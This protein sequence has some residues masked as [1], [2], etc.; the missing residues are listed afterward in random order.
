MT[1]THT[2]STKDTTMSATHAHVVTALTCA[3]TA[4]AITAP[5]RPVTMRFANAHTAMILAPTAH[6]MTAHAPHAST[7]HKQFLDYK[8]ARRTL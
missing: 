5:A 4:P 3:S 2:A 8:P 1:G 6:V 7:Q